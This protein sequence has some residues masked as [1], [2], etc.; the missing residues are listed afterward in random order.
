[1]EHITSIFLYRFDLFTAKVQS[2]QNFTKLQISLRSLRLCGKKLTLIQHS[3]PKMRKTV[4]KCQYFVRFPT[5]ICEFI[6]SIA[7]NA[8]NRE[9]MSRKRAFPAS[10]DNDDDIVLIIF[11][12]IL[13]RRKVK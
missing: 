7:Q 6:E 2:P 5:L 8:K 4:K 9:E 3:R 1:M 13:E 11:I 12:I 10:D